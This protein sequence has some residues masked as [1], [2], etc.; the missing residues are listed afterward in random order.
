MGLDEGFNRVT[1]EIKLSNPELSAE[2]AL[3]NLELR[4]GTDRQRALRNLALRTDIE[5]VKNLVTLL[6][7][8]DKFG[9]SVA[10][11][12]RVYSET[13]RT[14]RMQKAEELAAK[15]PVKLVF[16]LI[17]FIFPALFVAILGPATIRIYRNIIIGG[18]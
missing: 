2:F 11:T 13:F 1:H 16:P 5:V 8:A 4:A 3:L 10:T 14:Q 7:Q 15:I 9:T 12:L 6:V 18:G 17:L